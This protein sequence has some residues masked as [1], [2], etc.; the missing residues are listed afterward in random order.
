MLKLVKY[1]II[2]SNNRECNS[3]V[4]ELLPRP[5]KAVVV[6]SE[7]GIRLA[8]VKLRKVDVEF[9]VRCRH[10]DHLGFERPQHDAPELFQHRWV[11]VL[12]P[13]DIFIIGEAILIRIRMN[14]GI[15]RRRQQE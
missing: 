8:I 6:V 5:F 2:A 7:D 9:G 1:N 3:P 15:D 12:N 13:I 11:Q 14:K 10:N 4:L